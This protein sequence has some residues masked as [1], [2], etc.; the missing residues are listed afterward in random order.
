M[1]VDIVVV[2]AAFLLAGVVA[3]L[4]WPRLVDP[5]IV[6]RT[7][8]GL[9]T[10]EVG[11]ARRFGNEGWYA[12]LGGT[13]GLTLGAVLTGWRRTHEVVTVLVVAAGALL[14]AL[15][16]ARLGTWVGPDAPEQ[17]L[18][19]AGVGET[20]PAQVRLAA[21]AA[22]LVWPVA[23]LLGS[24]MVLWAAPRTSSSEGPRARQG[25]VFT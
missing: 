14:A 9:V 12:V 17:L 11:L 3:G 23:A 20:A 25:K 22:Y 13:G 6:S 1:A 8:L 4:L 7:R 2:L 10:D 21:E 5:V 16:S 15:V 24:I 18:A 19:G